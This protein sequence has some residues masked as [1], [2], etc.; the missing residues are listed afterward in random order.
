M[1]ISLLE[2][3]GVSL[4]KVRTIEAMIADVDGLYCRGLSVVGSR[5]NGSHADPTFR[6]VTE[7]E[8][9]RE[10]LLTEKEQAAQDYLA[11]EM[12]LKTVSDNEMRIILYWRHLRHLPWHEVAEKLGPGNSS[13][14]VK[15][16]YCRYV[17]RLKRP[18]PTSVHSANGGVS[19]C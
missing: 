18:L 17:R 3:A 19:V 6:A 12:E 15:Q 14:M 4:A 1:N 7:L 10:K 11:A 5:N 13:D 16:R 2:N 9:L 8:R